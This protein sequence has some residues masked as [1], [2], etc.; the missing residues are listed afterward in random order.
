MA[1]PKWSWRY[2]IA[3]GR[4]SA[5]QMYE[6]WNFCIDKF[7]NDSASRGARWDLSFVRR[8]INPTSWFPRYYYTRV[9]VHFKQQEDLVL[10][11]LT[12]AV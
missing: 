2:R 8:R 1:A 6:L 9:T 3:F 10:F 12:H 4:L 5:D 11:K 7:G